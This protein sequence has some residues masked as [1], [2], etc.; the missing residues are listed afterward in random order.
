MAKKYFA[1]TF[2][3]VAFGVEEA[4]IV[5]YLRQLPAVAGARAYSLETWREVCTLIVIGA[6]AWLGGKDAAQRTR[7]YCFAFGIWDIVYYLALWLLSGYPRLTEPDV[8]FLIPVPW[9]APVWAPMAFA[10]VLV[11]IGLFGIVRKRSALLILGFVLALV[12]FVYESMLKTNAY[13]VWLFAVAFALVL[14][15][16]PLRL[17]VRRGR[18]TAKSIGAALPSD[19]E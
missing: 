19:P 11:L 12:S 7:A 1:L 3:S 9:I 13:P 14:S 15:A 4:I 8:L 2:F 16:M 10:F 5:V 18:R 6:I 17:R